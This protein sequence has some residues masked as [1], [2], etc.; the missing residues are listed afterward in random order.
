M[1]HRT[2]ILCYRK[3]ID[4]QSTGV[5][6]R[7]VLEDSYKEFKMQEQLYNQQQQH[8][9]L[10]E[11]L[12]LVPGAEQL[13]F[14]VSASVIPYLKQLKEQVPDLTNSLG[15]PFLKFDHYRFELIESDTR[16][17]S[18]HKVAICFFSEPMIWHDSV[19]NYLVLSAKAPDA[20]GSVTTDMIAQQPGLGI[21]SMQNH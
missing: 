13:H 15:L 7:A 20:N 14:L 1:S 8:H 16:S 6:E 4:A 18:S 2:I 11:L 12:A 5:W 10:T 19:G 3:I 17:I 21:Y 9:M